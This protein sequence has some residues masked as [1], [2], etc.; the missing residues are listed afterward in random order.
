MSE[1]PLDQ[2]N[3]LIASSRN[4]RLGKGVIGKTAQVATAAILVWGVIAWRWSENLI[5][6][7]G[8]FAVGVVMTIFANWFIRAS[9]SFAKQNPA[10]AILEGADFLEYKR[11]EVQ[12]K[13]GGISA[14]GNPTELMP[15][16]RIEE[17]GER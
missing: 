2:L 11:L 16:S 10:Q 8:L 4:V 13:D 1:D 17:K 14:V 6:D 5:A 9:Q 12:Q 15:K 3:R 7:A